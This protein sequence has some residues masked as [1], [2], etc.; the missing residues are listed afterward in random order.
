MW[1]WP[2][3]FEVARCVMRFP[4]CVFFLLSSKVETVDFAPF[5]IFP[6]LQ[7]SL[8]DLEIRRIYNEAVRALDM[9]EIMQI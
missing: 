6:R 9:G 1:K 3:G 7:P 2:T 8:F 5:P 4:L